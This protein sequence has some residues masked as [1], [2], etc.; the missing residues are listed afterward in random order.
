MFVQHL[1][2]RPYACW[3]TI[4]EW[5]LPCTKRSNVAL[6]YGESFPF[7]FNWFHR[8]GVI[9]KRANEISWFEIK[10]SYDCFSC[11]ARDNVRFLT[12]TNR[13]SDIHI[14]TCVHIVFR[15]FVRMNHGK[16]IPF[17]GADFVAAHLRFRFLN[18]QVFF[19]FFSKNWIWCL[20]LKIIK[21]H[22]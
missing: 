20:Y 21:K 22:E 17:L 15:L 3:Y 5:L 14:I 8:H 11:C 1:Y 10:V 9:L 18:Q 16:N 7:V 2:E 19:S 6:W 4:I 13:C 12:K